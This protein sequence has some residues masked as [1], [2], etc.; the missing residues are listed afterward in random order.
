MKKNQMS[1]S[2]ELRKKTKKAILIENK[3]I[4]V[5]FCLIMLTAVAARFVTAKKI[6]E[7]EIKRL[8]VKIDS[9]QTQRDSIQFSGPAAEPL[10]HYPWWEA[11]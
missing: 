3:V 8:T 7:E 5:I 6:N 11:K 9:L 1:D 4:I 2:Y 10:H